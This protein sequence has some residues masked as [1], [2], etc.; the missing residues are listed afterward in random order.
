MSP[1]CIAAVVAMV[2]PVIAWVPTV[3]FA[4]F[5]VLRLAVDAATGAGSRSGTSPAGSASWPGRR[6][7]A[8]R[9]NPSSR[10]TQWRSSSPVPSQPASCS[11]F[12]CD[13]VQSDSA[14]L[15]AVPSLTSWWKFRVYPADCTADGPRVAA[16]GHRHHAYRGPS[17]QDRRHHGESCLHAA[18][19]GCRACC[20]RSLLPPSA[21]TA[22]APGTRE[23]RLRASLRLTARSC[24]RCRACRRRLFG[25]RSAFGGAVS[26]TFRKLTFSER[27]AVP[28]AASS[29]YR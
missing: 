3:E 13:H 23:R 16:G 26:V 17:H 22:P 19:G 18:R 10:A 21:G 25:S 28:P 24:Q 27:P 1:C 12:W 5:L 7:R 4:T 8:A 14:V 2:L 6:R 29:R 15:S 11:D 20:G 9:R